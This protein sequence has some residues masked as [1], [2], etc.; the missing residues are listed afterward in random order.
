[1]NPY[2]AEA[3]LKFAISGDTYARALQNAAAKGTGRVGA[4]VLQAISSQPRAKLMPGLSAQARNTAELPTNVP[5]RNQALFDK[6]PRDINTEMPHTGQGDPKQRARFNAALQRGGAVYNQPGVQAQI[7]EAFGPAIKPAAPTN[8]GKRIMSTSEPGVRAGD[9]TGVLPAAPVQHDSFGNASLG[10]QAATFVRGGRQFPRAQFGKMAA[11]YALKTANDPVKKKIN[12]KGV[13]VWIEWEKGETRRYKNKGVV[14]YERLMEA[15]YGYIPGT[16]DSDGEE[17]DVY[18]GPD[19]TSSTAY[20]VKQMKKDG[21]FDEHKVMLGYASAAAARASYDHHMSNTPEKFGGMREIPVSALVALFGE[22]KEASFGE[23]AAKAAPYVLGI[24]VP[25]ATAGGILASKPGIRANVKNL[26][27]S[28]GTV[29]EKDMAHELPQEVVDTATRAHQALTERGIDPSALRIAVDAPPGSGKT[30]LSRA[31]AN[32]LG[33]KH[34]GLDWMPHNKFHS[35][36]GGGHIEEMPRAPKA[37]EILEHYNLLRSYDPEMFDV[38]LHIQKDPEVIKQQ[39]LN[40]GRSAGMHTIMDYDK[41]LAV[42]RMAYDTLAGDSI[43]LGNG[44]MMKVRPKEG[45]GENQLDQ[46][47]QAKGIDPTKLT[48]H[49]KLLS[50]HEGKAVGGAGWTPYFKSPFTGGET[51]ALAAS[52]PVGIGAAMAARRFL[53]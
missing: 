52:V 33:V 45:W 5:G 1:M 9:R 22:N 42:G 7:E 4:P 12:V 16:L 23:F 53:G 39:I 2:V 11:E 3:L 14:K 37:G 17:L 20:V 48:R 30:T 46:Q 38:A 49:Q 19:R 41:S 34:Y 43:D 27:E 13:P 40:R 44:V 10:Q 47:L 51:A 31:L 6:L 8:P 15:D 35:L 25:L 18:V 28:K 50:L 21:T 24:G 32:E 26:I 36:M 29:Q